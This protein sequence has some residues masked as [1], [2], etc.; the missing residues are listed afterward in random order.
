[1]KTKSSIYYLRREIALL[2]TR[3]AELLRADSTEAGAELADKIASRRRELLAAE[4]EEIDR[5][6]QVTDPELRVILYGRDVLCKQSPPRWDPGTR[7]TA[8]EKNITAACNL[9]VLS[10]FCVLQ[11]SHGYQARAHGAVAADD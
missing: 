3:L 2:E 8:A 9:S 10:V 7:Q 4:G 5:I 11:W 6:R 1:M